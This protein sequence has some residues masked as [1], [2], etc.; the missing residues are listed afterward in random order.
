MAKR[1][2][3]GIE[4]D[5]KEEVEFV[6]WLEEAQTAGF[7]VDWHYQPETFVLSERKAYAPH[8]SSKFLLHPQKYTPDFFVKFEKKFND[9]F[10]DVVVYDQSDFMMRVDKWGA[11]FDIKGLFGR[12]MNN[13]SAYTFPVL[14]KWLYDKHHIFVNKVVARDMKCKEKVTKQGFFSK[15]WV[16]KAAAYDRRRVHVRNKTFENCKLIEEIC[17]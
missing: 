14:Q 11:Y 7:V 10:P 6:Q 15:T 17:N 4:Y 13:S 3:N 9:A 2:Y 1:E 16:P 8:G 12:G 5:S